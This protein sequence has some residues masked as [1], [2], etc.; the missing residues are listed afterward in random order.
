MTEA[1][2]EEKPIPKNVLELLMVYGERHHLYE[3]EYLRFFNSDVVQKLTNILDESI[4]GEFK[5]NSKAYLV[6]T[7]DSKE[8]ISTGFF[9]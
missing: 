1:N 7:N 4:L 5:E 3:D 9:Y 2:Y 8:V 6:Y